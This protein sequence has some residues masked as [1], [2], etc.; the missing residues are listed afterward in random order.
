MPFIVS[1]LGLLLTG[2]I[3]IPLVSPTH[4]GLAALLLAGGFVSVGNQL[5]TPLLTSLASKSVGAD[6][7][8]GTLG[9]MQSLGS[10]ARFVGPLVQSFL[11]YSATAAQGMDDHS[12]RVTF[13][14]AAAITFAACLLAFYLRMRADATDYTGANLTATSGG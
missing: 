5:A 6:V 4:G 14:T 13:W 11:I 1:G 9:M 12:L 7:Q 3:A 10:L 2:L 8:G